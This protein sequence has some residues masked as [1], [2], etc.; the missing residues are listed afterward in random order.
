MRKRRHT[1][2][3][4]HRSPR[5]ALEH[6]AV[7]ELMKNWW[8][9][10][11][12]RTGCHPHPEPLGNRRSWLAHVLRPEGELQLD[13]GACAALQHRG[14]SLLL[15]GV[16]AVRGEFAA[17]QPVQL[18]APDGENLG[19]GLCSMDSD[20]LRAAMNDPSPGESS[21]VVVHRDGLVLRSR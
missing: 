5:A 6:T 3:V 12:G 10:D 8:P 16:T 19:R 9:G 11:G 15:V 1:D 18:L 2:Q 17:N 4:R 20:Q 21:P 7:I 13:A 14:A